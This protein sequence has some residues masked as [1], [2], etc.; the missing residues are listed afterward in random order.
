MIKL[1]NNYITSENYIPSK[2]ARN[3]ERIHTSLAYAVL[4]ENDSFDLTFPAAGYINI[5]CQV[6][7]PFFYHLDNSP[8]S[9]EQNES[10]IQQIGL[11]QRFRLKG[12]PSSGGMMVVFIPEETLTGPLCQFL[13][14][15]VAVADTNRLHLLKQLAFDHHGSEHI[16]KS[17]RMQSI[18]LDALALQLEAVSSGTD[19][20]IHTPLLEKI[21]QAQKLIEQD[22]SRSYTISELAKAVGTNEQYLKKYFKQHVGKTIMHYTLETKMLYAKKLILNDDVRIAD[23]ARMTGYKH[24]THFSMSFKKFFGILPTSLRYLVFLL[25]GA[26][27]E[28]TEFEIL[29]L[30]L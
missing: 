2:N 27:V 29:T 28:L 5:F 14:G 19:T 15:R 17:I 13:H 3:F 7:V 6:S 25:Q 11:G 16:A 18:L 24:A 10:I 9:A 20:A 8:I 22:L 30:L 23:V 12:A 4:A 26:S 21:M 1:E